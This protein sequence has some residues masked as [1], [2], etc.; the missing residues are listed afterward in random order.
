MKSNRYIPKGC[1]LFVA[2]VLTIGGN[3]MSTQMVRLFTLTG[4]APVE[5]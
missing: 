3:T 2:Q 1:K 5:D 4:F